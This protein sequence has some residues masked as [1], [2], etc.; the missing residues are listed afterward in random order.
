MQVI[1]LTIGNKP[2][3]TNPFPAVES[4]DVTLICATPSRLSLALV[5]ADPEMDVSCPFLHQNKQGV[6]MNW[7]KTMW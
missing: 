3:A 5:S 1:S 2:T 4:A 7:G 6:S